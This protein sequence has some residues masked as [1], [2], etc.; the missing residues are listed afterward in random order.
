MHKSFILILSVLL[1]TVGCTRPEEEP[2]FLRVDNISFDKISGTNA[3]VSA[4]V[5]FYNPNDVKMKLRKV[6]LDVDLEGVKIGSI[7]EQV[8]TK[9]GARSEFSVPVKASFDLTEIGLLNGLLSIFGG[10][11]VEVRFYGKIG[12]SVHG[13]PASVAI[14]HTEKI[15]M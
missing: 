5:V 7:A 9:I 12:V 1:I 3:D 4:E 15:R 2:Q 11:K 6:E 13:Y 10:K 8:H 14:D